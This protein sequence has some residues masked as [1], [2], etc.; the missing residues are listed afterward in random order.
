VKSNPLWQFEGA[1][2]AVRE[3]DGEGSCGAQLIPLYRFY[4]NGK[5]GAPNHRYTTNP[6][7]RASMIASGWVP[8]GSGIGVV[9]C[10]LANGVT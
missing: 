4:N 6:A 7:L 10:V 2:F 3:A 9:G 8:E 5:G 1:P